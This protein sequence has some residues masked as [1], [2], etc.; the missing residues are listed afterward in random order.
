MK[1]WSG[2]TILACQAIHP[3]SLL[4]SI[5]LMV[6]VLFLTFGIKGGIEAGKKVINSVKLFSH[7]ANVGDSKSLIIHPA[8]TTHSQLSM[9]SKRLLAWHQA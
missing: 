6:K 5:C 8:S 7:L 1:L 3:M 2:L 4:R 9:N